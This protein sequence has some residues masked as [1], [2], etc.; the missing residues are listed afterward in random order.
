MHHK[1]NN[2]INKPDKMGTMTMEKQKKNETRNV[3]DVDDN[4]FQMFERR[5]WRN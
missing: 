5:R 4:R 3:N 1:N 2:I